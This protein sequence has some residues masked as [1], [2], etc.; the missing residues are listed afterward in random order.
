MKRDCLEPT[1]SM[2]SLTLSVNDASS[3]I[4]VTSQKYCKF[5]VHRSRDDIRFIEC[6]HCELHFEDLRR[7]PEIQ[8]YPVPA[9]TI[10]IQPYC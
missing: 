4:T 3:V 6:L 7:N 1:I 10:E 5:E 9:I 8:H 2:L